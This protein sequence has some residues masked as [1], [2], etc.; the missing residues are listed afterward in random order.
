MAIKLARNKLDRLKSFKNC[1]STLPCNKIDVQLI[2]VVLY[3]D[4]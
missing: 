2:L 3:G 4:R 1:G